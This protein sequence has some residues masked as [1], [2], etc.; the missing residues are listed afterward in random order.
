[1]NQFE[2][3]QNFTYHAPSIDKIK[4]YEEIRQMAKHFAYLLESLCPASPDKNI[5]FEKLR[6]CVMWANAA[7]ATEKEKLGE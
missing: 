6:E 1:M 3:E 2:I 7:I 5:S 4:K